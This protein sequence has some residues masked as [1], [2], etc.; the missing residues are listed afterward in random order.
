MGKNGSG[1]STLLATLSGAL[2]PVNG[3]IE[4]HGSELSK[5]SPAAR[6]QLLSIVLTDRPDTGYLTLYETVALGRSSRVSF[7]GRLRP[8]DKA[9]IEQALT[10]TGLIQLAHRRA[11]DLSDGE[12]RRLMVARAIAQQTP[13]MLLDEPLAFLDPGHKA[14]LLQ[15]L[16]SLR[17]SGKTILFSTHEPGFS[18]HAADRL[19]L[20]DNSGV[21]HDYRLPEQLPAD[22]IEKLFQSELIAFDVES[23]ALRLRENFHKSD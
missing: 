12:F 4:I 21:I 20:I 5:Y 23:R 15:L 18:L 14:E 9:I 13:V 8:S 7:S 11:G 10:E 2:R 22:E 19:L 16:C 17:D 1:K 3:K 6:S